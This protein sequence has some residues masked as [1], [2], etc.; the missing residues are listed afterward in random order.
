VR[1][2][3]RKKVTGA[4]ERI[5]LRN[6]LGPRP[7]ILREKAGESIIRGEES[8]KGKKRR[9]RRRSSLKREEGIN[10]CKNFGENP[11]A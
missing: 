1:R 3:K 5:P 11:S 8:E 10:I 7:S 2:G 4:R 6:L 9:I